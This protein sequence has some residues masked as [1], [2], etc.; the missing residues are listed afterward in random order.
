M[1]SAVNLRAEIEQR[2]EAIN[3]EARTLIDYASLLQSQIDKTARA[4]IENALSIAKSNEKR[5]SEDY[6]ERTT[7]YDED[8]NIQ[9]QINTL[10]E[11][12]MRIMLNDSETRKRISEVAQSVAGSSGVASNT[13]VD[14]MLDEIYNS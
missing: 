9:A 3:G 12:C 5:R 1:Q 7:R 11:T 2:R 14:E 10:A 4:I 6:Q 13:E 8:S